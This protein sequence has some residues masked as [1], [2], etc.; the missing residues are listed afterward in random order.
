MQIEE[1]ILEHDYPTT[2]ITA[3][4]FLVSLVWLQH[5]VTQLG[6][7]QRGSSY[8]AFSSLRTI[9]LITAFQNTEE[10]STGAHNHKCN[11]I[12]KCHQQTSIYI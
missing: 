1:P 3:E 8:P 10:S 11:K 7:E 6:W 9:A 12:S 2:L 5:P 4:S